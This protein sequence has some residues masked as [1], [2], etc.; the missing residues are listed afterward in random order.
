MAASTIDLDAE[1]AQLL[2]IHAAV[3]RAHYET[4][5]AGVIAYDAEACTNVRNGEIRIRHREDELRRFVEYFAGATYDEWDDVEPPIV[6]V[7]GDASIAWMIVHVRVRR[8]RNAEVQ[9][10]EY[11]GIETYEKREGRWAKTSE[12]STFK[13]NS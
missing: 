4:D 6:K 3:R 8:T 2:A 11:A 5:P 1:R 13:V 7:A 12:A 9:D 10:F